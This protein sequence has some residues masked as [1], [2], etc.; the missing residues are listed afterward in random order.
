MAGWTTQTNYK[1]TYS[2]RLNL[3][4]KDALEEF[5]I[6]I[7]I[8]LQHL[9]I[10]LFKEKIIIKKEDSRNYFICTL[11]GADATMYRGETGYV[12]L[13]KSIIVKDYTPTFP[14]QYRKIFEKRNQ[15]I[16][17]NIY[18]LLED[19]EFPSA[20]GAADF[21]TGGHYN[22]YDAW[23]KKDNPEI[24]LGQFLQ[25]QTESYLSKKNGIILRKMD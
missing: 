16:E 19:Q 8:I 7:R 3:S 24:S 2:G 9:G 6:N 11:R 18:S 4:E 13:K 10:S 21:V 22:G 23:K 15:L 1:Q 12:V 14:K 20:S 5:L 17:E 25:M